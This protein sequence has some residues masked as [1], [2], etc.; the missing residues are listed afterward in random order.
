MRIAKRLCH[1]KNF[2]K[3][4]TSLFRTFL[5]LHKILKIK[6]VHCTFITFKTAYLFQFYL[7][8]YQKNG[9]K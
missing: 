5:Y 3:L 7:I 8:L 1:P 4:N 2:E 6:F 9:A